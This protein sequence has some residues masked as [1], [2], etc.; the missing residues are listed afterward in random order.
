[1]KLKTA[2]EGEHG[3]TLTI[4]ARTYACRFRQDARAAYHA[5]CAAFP[6]V[7]ACGPNLATART[8]LRHEIE[9]L[10]SERERRYEEAFLDMLQSEI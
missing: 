7:F 6:S 5:T 10:L 2:K 3:E 8:A 9:A 4:G 1:M